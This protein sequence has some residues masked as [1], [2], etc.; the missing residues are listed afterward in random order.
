MQLE[1]ITSHTRQHNHLKHR[2]AD[3][4][5]GV[6]RRYFCITFQ[7]LLYSNYWDKTHINS[8]KYIHTQK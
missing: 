4:L 1:G 8:V 5:G 2:D 3:S 6:D 7:T